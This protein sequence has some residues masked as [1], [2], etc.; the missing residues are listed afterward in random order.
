MNTRSGIVKFNNFQI[1]LD[2]GCSS[3]ILMGRL[4]E[5]MSTEKD[6]QMQWHTQAGNSTTGIKVNVDF[7]LPCTQRNEC[8]DVEMSC[9]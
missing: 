3:M 8:R 7:T 9:G 4:V 6:N 1:I 5:K 2:S